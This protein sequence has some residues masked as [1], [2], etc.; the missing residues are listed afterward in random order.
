MARQV[1]Q[2]HLDSKVYYIS[3][4]VVWASVCAILLVAPRP[5]LLTTGA[6]VLSFLLAPLLY[7]FNYYCVTRQIE[8]ES[9]RPSM[10][11][12]LVAAAGVA[13]MVL[14]SILFVIF[15]VGF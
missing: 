7:V 11:S 1:E 5:V 6:A 14:A 10:P 2:A 4:V 3:I 12:R 9:L 13:F 8:D 15:C